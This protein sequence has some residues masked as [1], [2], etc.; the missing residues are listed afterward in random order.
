MGGTGVKE[1]SR[2]GSRGQAARMIERPI[3]IQSHE[4]G[5]G[6][7]ITPRPVCYCCCTISPSIDY[8]LVR[9]V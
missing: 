2:E 9:Q 1:T 8:V 4:V 3:M 7:E 6:S 5:V